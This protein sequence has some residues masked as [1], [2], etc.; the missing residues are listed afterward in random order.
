MSDVRRGSVGVGFRFE[1]PDHGIE[2]G[3]VPLV[4]C[5]HPFSLR[6]LTGQPGALVAKLDDCV[7]GSHAQDG[8]RI[9]G[10]RLVRRGGGCCIIPHESMAA[11]VD[12]NRP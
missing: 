2:I 9:R 1:Q 5:Q 8:S 12:I 3:Q 6:D 11:S 7:V 10:L 4:R